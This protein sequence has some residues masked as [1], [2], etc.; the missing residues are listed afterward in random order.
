MGLVRASIVVLVILSAC[1]LV[2][3][4]LTGPHFAITHFLVTW[5]GMEGPQPA[6][7]GTAAAAAWSPSSSLNH[8]HFLPLLDRVGR[9][10]I[11]FI[12]PLGGVQMEMKAI[13]KYVNLPCPQDYA[14]S[15]T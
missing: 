14:L 5:A 9:H 11:I 15:N 1:A 2:N 4:I 12:P 10:P 13:D 6:A 7:A 3:T 8:S